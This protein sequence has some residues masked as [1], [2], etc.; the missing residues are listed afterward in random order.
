MSITPD[1]N[2]LVPQEFIGVPFL[3]LGRSLTEGA[4][5][6]GIAW[7]YL[8][9]H[10]VEVPDTD[11][12]PIPRDWKKNDAER[13]LREMLKMG[14][15]AP[16]SNLKKFDIVLF[17]LSDRRSRMP[18]HLAVM[19]SDSCFLHI[20]EPRDGYEDGEPGCVYGRSRVDQI[21]Q[22][23]KERLAGAIRLTKVRSMIPDGAEVRV[24]L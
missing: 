3:R 15:L 12:M 7:L 13:M 14:D 20:L 4:D 1:W 11:G 19:V 10:G 17:V 16:M 8:K 22:F 23:W 6:I 21:D 9:A 18:D 24:K 5:C 2:K